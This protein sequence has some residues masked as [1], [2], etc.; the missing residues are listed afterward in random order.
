MRRK[1]R[2]HVF[3]VDDEPSVRKAASQTLRRLGVEVK[4]F[5]SG[6]DCLEQ[7]ASGPCD[8]LITDVKMPEMDGIELLGEAK[9]VAPWLPVLVITG[10]ADV[11]LAVEAMKMGAADFIEKPLRRE[12]LTPKVEAILK[13]SG[14]RDPHLGRPLTR[15]ELKV[16]TLVL[17]GKKNKEIAALLGRSIRTVE[18]HRHNINRKLGARNH[19]ELVER[20]IEMGLPKF[21]QGRSAGAI[22]KK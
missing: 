4:C 6:A 15:T 13:A 18:D 10:Y 8:L 11:P 20:A 19:A 1:S 17:H 22:A 14:P 7:L 2:H 12:N 3:F 16:L 21:P 5:A 9:Q